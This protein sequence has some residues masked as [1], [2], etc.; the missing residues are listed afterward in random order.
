MT[1][2]NTH[3]GGKGMTC[4][5]WVGQD[6]LLPRTEELVS[7]SGNVEEERQEREGYKLDSEKTFLQ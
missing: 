4:A 1:V 2:L 6:I 3:L 5:D 7:F